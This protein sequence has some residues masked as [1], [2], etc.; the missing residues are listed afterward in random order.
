MRISLLILFITANYYGISQTNISGI[1]NIYTPVISIDYCS[2]TITVSNPGGFSIGDKVLLIQMKGATIDLNNSPSFGSILNYNNAGNFEFGIIKTIIGNKITF[3][4]EILRAY[5]TNDKVQLVRV[6][7][8]NI[9][10][11]KGLLTCQN[12]NGSTGGILVFE[13]TGDLYLNANIDA[14]GK[15]FSGGQFQNVGSSCYYYAN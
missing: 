5:N 4:N 11:V 7:V 15:G 9:A 10:V 1:I 13:C 3:I 12:W 2:Q 8:Y 14:S 6:P